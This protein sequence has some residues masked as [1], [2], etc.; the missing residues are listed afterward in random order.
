MVKLT[1]GQ[2]NALLTTLGSLTAHGRGILASDESTGTIGKRLVKAGLENTEEVRRCY[3][4]LLYTGPIGYAGIGGVILFNETLG[5]SASD[6]RSFVEC[7]TSQGVLVGI[8]VD[9]G[10]EMIE[11]TEDGETHTKGMATLR[12]RIVQYKAQGAVFAKWRAALRVSEAGLPSAA[13]IAVN[14]QELAEYARICQENGLV[15]IVEPEL[16]IDGAHSMERFA[17]ASEQV[18]HAVMH[19]LWSH[20]V[21]LEGCLIKPQM[22]VPGT[23][24]AG[25]RPS[26]DDI[27]RETLKVL[28][29]LLWPCSL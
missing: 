13:A 28:Y 21:F 14:A 19:A 5:Q 25:E 10:L 2:K 29:F 1:E 6:G 3:R 12:E 8:K 11:G 26:S 18:L 9:E 17:A 23:E 7:L 15:P 4:E 20:G 16:L 27:A 24:Y 22:I